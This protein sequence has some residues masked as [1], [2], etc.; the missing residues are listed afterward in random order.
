MTERAHGR[1]LIP[2]NLLRV[3]AL[4]LLAVYTAACAALQ[5]TTLSAEAPAVVEAPAVKEQAPGFYRVTLGDFKVTAISDGTLPLEADKVLANTTPAK[6]NMALAK[7][8]LTSPVETSFNAFLVDTGNKQVLI[9][10][11]TG[12]L[13]GPRLGKLWDNLAAAGYRPDQV[14]EVYVT[15]LHADHVGGLM[16]GD[17][18]A[19]PN[20]TVRADQHDVDYWL[21][22]ENLAK[23]PEEMKIFFQG[24]RA[25]LQPYIAAGKFK[26]FDGDTDLVPGVKAVPMRGH[27][28]GHAFYVAESK[29]EKMVFWGDLVHVAAVQ[30]PD[31]SVTIVFDVASKAAATQRKKAL[32]EA[33]KDG[34]LI[35]AA[36]ISFPG[37]GRVRA[38]GKGYTWVPVN[39]SANYSPT[40]DRSASGI[41]YRWH[42]TP[43]LTTAPFWSRLLASHAAVSLTLRPEVRRR[44][45]CPRGA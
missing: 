40:P 7:V 13:L 18:M 8:Y 4:A 41:P 30:L 10:V 26:A 22:D 44:P 29:G 25:S 6:V 39:H 35:G 21:S 3:S 33:A 43:Q 32:A 45:R 1:G 15:H 28:P 24:A 38:D 37:I 19:F 17:R 16:T 23:S 9:D 14:D 31:P 27:T 5:T 11:G 42:P 20:A 12:S 34:Y 2:T 36:H